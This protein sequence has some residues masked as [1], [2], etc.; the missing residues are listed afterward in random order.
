VIDF[1]SF[2]III[3]E[4]YTTECIHLAKK[5]IKIINRIVREKKRDYYDPH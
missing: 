5:T 2:D 3:L 4:I 1:S